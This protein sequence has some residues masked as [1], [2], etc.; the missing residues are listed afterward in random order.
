MNKA[1]TPVSFHGDVLWAQEVDGEVFVAMRQVCEA[2]SLDW[3]S[4]HKRIERDPVL[5]EGMV[6][7]TIPSRGGEQ[8]TL[9]LPLPLLNGWLFG[10]D[11]NR[12]KDPDTRARVL[13]YKRECYRVLY[14]HFHR[15]QEPAA[16]SPDATAADMLPRVS[17]VRECRLL[18]GKAAAQALWRDLGLP[19]PSSGGAAPAP[20]TEA[21]R[22]DISRFLA[23]LTVQDDA[24]TVRASALYEAYAAWAGPGAVSWTMFGRVLTAMGFPKEKRGVV[25]YAGLRLK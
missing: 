9:C 3:S 17:L 8:D 20:V 10:I 6:M 11:A 16:P 23:D 15:P 14:E 13:D 12:I 7:M 25:I 18:H 22:Y 24:A 19:A 4:Q 2:L 5:V 1:L 21:D